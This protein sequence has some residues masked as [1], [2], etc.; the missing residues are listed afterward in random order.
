MLK[1][2]VTRIPLEI[3]LFLTLLFASSYF[4]HPVDYD[5]SRTRL[6]MVSAMV[7]FHT[8][9]I[10]N[11]QRLQLY[12]TID[13]S[14]NG[15][16]QYSNKAPG[17]AMIAAPVYGL[18]KK[19][20]PAKN[21]PLLSFWHRYLINVFTNGLLF[22]IA[23]LVLFR[24]GLRWSGD[25]LSALLGVF[26]F[27]FGSI[28]WSHSQY[29]SGHLMT[30]ILF[31]FGFACLI[32]FHDRPGDYD[33]TFAKIIAFCGG[34]FTGFGFA[35][36]YTSVFLAV[37]L[38]CYLLWL[39]PPLSLIVLFSL[40]VAFPLMMVF[41]Y[42]YHCFGSIFSTGYQHLVLEE[43]VEGTAKGFLGIGL[44]KP[45]SLL[46]LL[47]SPS[48][49]LFFLMPV[50]I[51]SLIGLGRMWRSRRF[52]PEMLVISAIAL[53]YVIL[54]S[55][56]FGWHGGWTYGPRYFVPMLPFLTLALFFSPLRSLPGALLLILSTLLVLP[57]I[58]IMPHT[59]PVFSNPIVELIIPMMKTGYLPD[60]WL[61]LMGFGKPTGVLVGIAVI[62][63]LV[64]FLLMLGF[65]IRSVAPP[66]PAG[67][68]HRILAIAVSTV[69]ITTILFFRSPETDRAQFY[70][71]TEHLKANYH[72]VV[73]YFK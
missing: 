31:L 44:P 55:G 63:L 4:H 5:N 33:T 56:Y 49:G 71:Y 73:K 23:G 41:S 28:A 43:F 38:F 48:R 61:S 66:F 18:I 29:F 47:F 15:G 30:G 2:S 59:P 53:W 67:N 19:L 24:L 11:L 20:V 27:S 25:V 52:R 40:G 14:S 64:T 68:C 46:M 26:A 17:A 36:E 72:Q 22:A 62:L 37:A 57:S 60:S 54:I 39:R 16:K 6:M 8:Y 12:H 3:L 32:H 9:A 65:R 70:L 45:H 58:V 21:M 51:F 34:I 7:D 50:F 42:N 13:V 69:I 1:K 35:C 10:D